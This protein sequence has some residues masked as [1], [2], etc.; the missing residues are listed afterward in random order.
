MGW[1]AW[2]GMHGLVRERGGERYDGNI[3]WDI[4]ERRGCME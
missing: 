3:R 2:V 1:D 4:G